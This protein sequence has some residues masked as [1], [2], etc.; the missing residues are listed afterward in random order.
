MLGPRLPPAPIGRPIGQ[1]SSMAPGACFPDGQQ[2]ITATRK[3]GD[4]VLDEDS[5][6]SLSVLDLIERLMSLNSYDRK[7]LQFLEGLG[8]S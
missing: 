2:A 6:A 1:G 3:P 7:L 8:D 5:Q 4:M